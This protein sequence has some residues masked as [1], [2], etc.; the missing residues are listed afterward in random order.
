MKLTEES[1]TER[2]TD[3]ELLLRYRQGDVEAFMALYD[4]YRRPLYAYALSLVRD[5][6]LAE[7]LLQ[8]VCVRLMTMDA[9]RVQE[10]VQALAYTAVRNLA[11]DRARRASVRRQTPP[12]SVDRAED[13]HER[14]EVL[15]LLDRLPEEQREV[16]MLKVYG[17]LTLAEA[18]EVTQVPLATA[19]SRYR[20]AL[21]KLAQMLESSG[22]VP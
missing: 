20:Y 2:V 9:G 6:E 15:D 21:E 18:A 7:D 13:L 1:A 10:S 8:E 11:I 5:P 3:R 17:G 14:S 19:T 4:R 22:E 12:V 16:V